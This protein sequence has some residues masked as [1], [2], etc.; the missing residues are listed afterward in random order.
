M[1]KVVITSLPFKA[2]FGI[3]QAKSW[4]I[5]KFI[6]SNDIFVPAFVAALRASDRAKVIAFIQ[7]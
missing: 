6:S 2:R 4:S 1:V 7:F 3:W 5:N